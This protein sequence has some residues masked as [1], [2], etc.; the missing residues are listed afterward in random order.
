M[1]KTVAYLRVS[2]GEQAESGLGMEAKLE[3]IRR[4]VGEPG[5]VY[6]DEGYSGSSPKRPGLLEALEALRKGDT[7][8]VAKRDR[9]A[10]DLMLSC[11]IQKEVK[12][13]GARVISAAG[14][15]TESDD[16]AAVLMG[17]M[18][19]AFA[20][21][22]RSI[23]GARTAAA[24]QAKRKRGE[25]T[26]GDV[27]FGWRLVDGKRLVVDEDEQQV[28]TLASELREKG[29]T[30]RQIGTELAK[31]GVMT[32]TGKTEWNPKTVMSLLKRAA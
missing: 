28:I 9:L 19:D 23:I 11:W 17:Q 18:I 24:L 14:E 20:Q 30:L 12:R 6:R 2:T 26:G 8:V 32:R 5:A 31:R 21:Y 10:R 4:V 15:G 1:A 25:K 22:E 3:A 7:L 13:R 29:W 16:P 27:P